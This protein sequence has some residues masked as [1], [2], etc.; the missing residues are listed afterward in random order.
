MS[1][2]SQL[3]LSDQILKAISELGFEKPSPIQEQAIPQLLGD[4]RDF[5]GLAQTGTGKTAAFGLPLIERIDPYDRT[6]QALILA[7]TRELGQQ[8]AQQL[9][10]F[11]K[12]V[13]DVN[14]LA[15]YGGTSIVNQ[16]RA[17]KRP[18]HIIIATPGRLIDLIQ[19]KA[20]NLENLQYLILDEADEMLNMGFKDD[21]DQILSYASGDRLTWLFSAT[22]STDIK[23]IV[24]Q[25]MNN[26]FEVKLTSENEVNTNIEHQF[27]LI[28]H[29]NKVEGLAR[30]VDLE[31]E[32]RG[33]VFCRTKRDTQEVAD[34]LVR[35]GYQADAI[36]GD[37]SQFQRDQVMRRFK[38]NRL[39][40]LIATDVAARGID[41]NDLTHVFHFALPDDIPYYTHRSGR[42]ARAGKKGISIVFIGG[43]EMYRI[44]LIERKLGIKFTRVR[45][46]GAEDIIDARLAN[47]TKNILETPV[48]KKIDPQIVEKLHVMLGNLSKEELT[49]KFLSLELDKIAPE[50]QEDL[51]E[52]YTRKPPRSGGGG[53]HY[54]GKGGRGGSGHRG[55]G[56]KKYSGNSGGS[57]DDGEKKKRYRKRRA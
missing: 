21:I 19:R 29:H 8:I 16:I 26:P 55:G 43:R 51:N 38:A 48:N 52:E 14:M 25:Y 3:G 50:T 20:I 1:S 13:D 41:V 6:T 31:P 12:H 45:I 40:L 46:P 34:I 36:H 4:D 44:N 7:P 35:K 17:L 2:F 30:F 18:T 39:Q 56:G 28:Q 33:V 32:M 15:V 23:R 10:L 42:T 47:W 49:E 22:M 27:A 57:S 5:I 24:S 54:S 37:L 11:S 9:K 53:G